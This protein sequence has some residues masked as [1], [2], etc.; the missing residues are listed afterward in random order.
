MIVFGICF[1]LFAVIFQARRLIYI[2]AASIENSLF[3]PA[4]AA[5]IV[6]IFL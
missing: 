2:E 6:S 3:A 5:G 1:V 4:I